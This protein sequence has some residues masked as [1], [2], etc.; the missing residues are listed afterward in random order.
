MHA[1]R[2]ASGGVSDRRAQNDCSAAHTLRGQGL[3]ANAVG[4]GS[5][6]GGASQPHATNAGLVAW[7]VNWS[8]SVI[9]SSEFSLHHRPDSVETGIAFG[10]Y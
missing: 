1:E 5:S 2:I 8:T 10:K 6:A 9:Q 7:A 3:E 4:S